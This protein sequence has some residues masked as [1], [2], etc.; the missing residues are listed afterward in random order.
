MRLSSA[1]AALAFASSA[2]AIPHKRADGLSVDVSGPGPT[3]T[4]VDELKFTA[5][6]TNTGSESLK[7]L[8]YGTI[9]DSLPYREL[10]RRQGMYRLY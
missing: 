2:V 1:L 3:V 4:S 8:K 7:V 10:P 5:T 9:L 6:V